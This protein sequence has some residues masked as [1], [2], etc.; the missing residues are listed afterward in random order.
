MSK[1]TQTVGSDAT[2][3]TMKEFLTASDKPATTAAPE[4]QPAKKQRNIAYRLFALLLAVAPI[5]VYLLLP[6]EIFITNE[7]GALA[8][9][10]DGK[11]LDIFINLF[12]G[13]SLAYTT[14]FGIVPIT[15]TT[16][17]FGIVTN[18]IMYLIPVAML[19]TVIAAII[20]LFS[21]MSFPSYLSA[22]APAW[23]CLRQSILR[24]S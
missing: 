21:G 1:K 3:E 7:A 9:Y 19:V 23:I 11:L 15:T 14:L 5:V 24:N 17:M 16:S 22:V 13:G 8:L 6:V 2:P 10:H 4:K 18:A 20:A 12:T